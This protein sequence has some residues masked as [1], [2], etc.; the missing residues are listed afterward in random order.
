MPRGETKHLKKHQFK[1]GAPSANPRGAQ[2]HNPAIKALKKLTIESFREIIE[3][4]VKSDLAAIKAIAEDPTTSGLQV[5]IAVAFLKAIKNG[6]YGVIERIAERIVGK[7]PDELKVT[8]NNT[9]LH[10]AI[11]KDKLKVALAQ[12]E[13]DV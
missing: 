3:L 13:S 5:G 2:L 4:V 7:I 12:L 10:G 9:N 8:S 11:D 1:K 6:D